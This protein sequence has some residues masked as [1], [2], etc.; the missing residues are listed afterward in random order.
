MEKHKTDSQDYIERRVR[1]ALAINAL[2]RI[3][4]IIEQI[5]TADRKA[6]IAVYLFALLFTTLAIALYFMISHTPR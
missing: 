5:E 3:R 2:K 6:R 4:N 1:N